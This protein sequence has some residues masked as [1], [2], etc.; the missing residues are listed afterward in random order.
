MIVFDPKGELVAITARRRRELGQQVAVI[1]PFNVTQAPATE[2]NPLLWL[3]NAPKDDSVVNRSARMA[4]MVA[5]SAGGGLL[6]SRTKH[7]THNPRWRR[8]RSC[9]C[10]M[11][12]RSASK[13]E[14]GQCG[15]AA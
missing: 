5:A 1:D 13:A 10:R 7:Y 6:G 9:R 12:R 11:T 4:S 2:I 8:M 3:R 14:V 15:F